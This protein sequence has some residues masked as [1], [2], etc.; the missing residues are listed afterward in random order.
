M[1]NSKNTKVKGLLVG[2]AGA[3]LLLGGSTYALWSAEDTQNGGAIVAGDLGLTKVSTTGLY[4]V[5]TDR[6]DSST[7]LSTLASCLPASTYTGHAAEVGS[8]NIVPGDSV[9]QVLGYKAHLKGDNLV[10]KMTVD[11]DDLTLT[12]TTGTAVTGNVKVYVDGTAAYTADISNMLTKPG[13]QTLGFFQA[14]T[15][16]SGTDDGTLV[17]LP[18]TAPT[19]ANVCVALELTW[20][21]ASTGK[22]ANKNTGAV[23]GTQDVG[24]DIAKFADGVKVSLIQSRDKDEVNDWAAANS[25]TDSQFK[26]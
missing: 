26:K 9:V 24:A 11:F 13:T 21:A 22:A 14:P 19:D 10:A 25:K 15:Q 16:N 17:K 6:L 4:D 3:A 12:Q 18:D 8:W 23:T 20:D 1:S 2:L 7:D 5:S